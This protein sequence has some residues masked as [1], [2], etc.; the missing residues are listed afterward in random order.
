MQ[1]VAA[2]VTI[3]RAHYLA[4]NG[5]FQLLRPRHLERPKSFHFLTALSPFLLRK[6][7]KISQ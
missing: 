4:G 2:A 7:K 3:R 5:S 1:E 6:K